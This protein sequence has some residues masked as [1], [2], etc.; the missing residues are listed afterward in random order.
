MKS[1]IF[2]LKNNICIINE[3]QI[4][5]SDIIKIGDAIFSIASSSKFYSKMYAKLYSKL[6][7]EFTFMKIIFDKNFYVFS[8]VF[9][10]I[11]Y[12]DPKDYDKY[13]ENNKKNEKTSCIG[14]FLCKF[15]D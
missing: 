10:N 6:I 14:T 4:E 5:C 3:N 13:C 1:K 11:T 15:N 7:S 2:I 8:E 9:H 12:C